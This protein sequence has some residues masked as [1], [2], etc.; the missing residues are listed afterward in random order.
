MG[1]TATRILLGF[2]IAGAIVLA[3][4]VITLIWLLA[5]RPQGGGTTPAAPPSLALAAGERILSLARG[6]DDILLLIQRT[7][8]GQALRL[9][10]PK[11]GAMVRDIPVTVAP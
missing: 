5:T 10:D 4:G 11:T 7:D 9:V 2:V 8:G 6:P 3:A 1:E